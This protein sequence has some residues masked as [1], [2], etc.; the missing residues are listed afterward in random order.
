VIKPSIV[1]TRKERRI[2]IGYLASA[3]ALMVLIV[4]FQLYK[5]EIFGT[6]LLLGWDSPAYIWMAKYVIAKG[7]ITMINIW[8]Y[9]SLYSQLLAFFG[10]L[11]GN[12]VIVERIL[13]PIFCALLIY[14][15]SELTYRITK[16]V[17]FAGLAAFLTVL[18]INVLR[19][20][21][22]LHRN[23][24]ALSLS[25]VVLLLVPKLDEEK[26]I[27]NK[28]YLSLILI[29]FIIA[30]TH[31]ETYFVLSMCLVLYGFLS[32]NLKKFMILTFACAVP[33]LILVL[34]FP[35]YFFG[36][37]STIVFFERQ[38]TVDEVIFWTGGSWMLLGFQIV[39][40]YFFYKSKLRNDKLVSL[41]FSWCLTILFIVALISMKL[42]PFPTEFAYRALLLMPVPILLALATSGFNNFLKRWQSKQ[43]SLSAKKKRSIHRLSISLIALCVIVSS[44][45]V[46]VQYAG[47]HLTPFIPRSGYEKI[48]IVKEYL[49]GSFSSAPVF[50]FRGDPPVW[51]V[52]LYRNYLAVEIGEHFAYYGEIENLFRLLPS[53]PKIKYN[54]WL[55]QLERYYITFY[56]DELIGNFSGSP[57]IMYVHD[58]HITSVEELFSH[59]IVIIAPEFY[60]LEI[61]Y[62][63][64]PFHIGEGIYVI[65]PNSSIIPSEI[66]YG[67]EVM[68]I[69]NGTLTQV[70]SEYT[71]ID[72]YDPSIVYIKVNASS[73]YR[74]YNFTN[75]PS[76]W[77]LQ[78]IEQ[79]DDPSFPEMGPR[80]I[81]GTK[82]CSGNDPADSMD[83]WSLPL[84][85]QNG[86]LQI[87]VL[88]KKEGFASLKV[89][90]KTDSWGNLGVRY[91]SSGIWNLAGYSSIGVWVKCNES[92]LFSITLVD[93]YKGSR[94]FWATEAEG[95]S[96]TTGWKRFV[97]NLTEYTSQTPDFV[98]HSVDHINLFVYSEPEKS[99][100]FWIDDLTVDTILDLEKFI[101]K[102]R[103]PVDET[104][105]AYFYTCMEDG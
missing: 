87:D 62:Y 29:L 84:S 81:N 101:F 86:T 24:M 3:S 18:S 63:L 48:M 61:P 90:G 56:F 85:E 41:I 72:L 71:Y 37:I 5:Y 103:V 91:D 27:L 51:Y 52:L 50:V 19:V 45:L 78:R 22:D 105:V 77:T 16:H 104:M 68:V 60:N 59:P 97:V 36:Y 100:S 89:S 9:P 102:D 17:H 76:N 33:V 21:S 13:P 40:S 88:S 12:I 54:A 57:P 23:L 95:G 20:L 32:R 28:K 99:L 75:F 10:Y 73:G 25:F 6:G 49:T 82:A 46:A 30:G 35:T 67:P 39:G 14:A 65:P 4:F 94:T 2:F 64:K 43:S 1:R 26:G 7:P 15:N 34:L 92:A 96:V 93:C 70:K 11:T 83:Y 8:G 55:F 58:S 44:A 66:T 42:A 53:E 79:D 98:I 47:A 69:R 74:S 31:F 80:R 38:L